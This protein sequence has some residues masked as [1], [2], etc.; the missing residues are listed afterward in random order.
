MPVPRRSAWERPGGD[1]KMAKFKGSGLSDDER[2][3]MCY[4][5]TQKLR[6]SA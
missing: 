6:T 4:G 3:D 2:D 5:F 1:Q